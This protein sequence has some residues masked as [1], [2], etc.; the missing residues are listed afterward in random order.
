[1]HEKLSTTTQQYYH[2]EYHTVHK[3]KIR[4]KEKEG[5]SESKAMLLLTQSVPANYLV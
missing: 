1:M 2:I 4:L 5:L 3:I